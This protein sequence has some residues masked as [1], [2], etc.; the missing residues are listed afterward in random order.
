MFIAR[1]AAKI[2]GV[3]LAFLA[4]CLLPCGLLVAWAVERR[5]DRHRAAIVAAV[6]RAVGASVT[7][8][9]V[10]HLRPGVVRLRG[11][12]I[13]TGDG[14]AVLQLPAI[15]IEE[16]ASELRLRV[17]RLVCDASAARWLA[18][19]GWDWLEQDARFPRTCIVDVADLAWHVDAPTAAGEPSADRVER[20]P[21]RVECVVRPQ[22]RA[23]RCAR[24]TVGG[25]AGDDLMRIV[26]SVAAPEGTIPAAQWEVDVAW[27]EPLPLAVA[28]AVLGTGDLAVGTQATVAGRLHAISRAG[29][30][31]GT[32]TARLGG[33]DLA[34]CGAAVGVRAAGLATVD[35]RRASWANDR[36]RD[37]D[38]ECV[39]GPGRVEQ[40]WLESVVATLGCQ[41]GPA[42]QS[43]QAEPDRS[44]DHAGFLLSL[45]DRGCSIASPARLAGPLVIAAGLSVLDPP[46]APVSADRLAWLLAAP[47]AVQ[48]PSTGPGA[49]LMSR[50]P[51]A[52]ERPDVPRGSERQ[53]AAIQAEQPGRRGGI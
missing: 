19:F 8:A 10:E 1:S 2:R 17:E 6:E 32:A 53:P 51:E 50:L 26:R 13:A 29:P 23:I 44:F 27:L 33:V 40:R 9:A 24:P 28:A 45:N 14:R 37:C 41:A 48:V 3:R 30:W 12:T 42:F 20:R 38:I 36:L 43:L 16:S 21:L 46:V 39:A 18:K 4:T 34:A 47:Q 22:V 15:E 52:V 7:V 11:C 25:R 35:I 31:E 5:S 49:W